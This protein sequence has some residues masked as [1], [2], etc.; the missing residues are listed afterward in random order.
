MLA[1][2]SVREYATTLRELHLKRQLI[3]IGEYCVLEASH[4]TQQDA[5]SQIESIEQ[6]LFSL[7]ETNETENKIQP[8]SKSLSHALSG[9]E[10]AVKNKGRLTGITT[11]FSDIDKLLGGAH[12]SDLV[13]LAGRPSMGKTALALN[14]AYNTAKLYE[15]EK[16]EHG[17]MIRVNGGKVAV[18]SLEMSSTQ[19]AS[20]LL[21]SATRL[22]GD[23][24]R[25]G[26]LNQEQFTQIA[27]MA[28]EIDDIPLFIDDTPAL[29]VSAIRQRSRR[30]KRTHGLDMIVIDY[31]QLLQLPHG[32]RADNRVQEIS[33]ITRNLKALAKELDI[34]VIALSQ[35][36]RAVESRDPPIPQLSDLRDSGAIEQD[37]DVVMFLYRAEYYLQRRPPEIRE[38][39]TD[40]KFMERQQKYQERLAEV[41]NIAQLFIAKQRHGPVGTVDLYFNADATL[42]DDFSKLNSEF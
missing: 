5:D 19:L 29:T 7:A 15:E 25:R 32:S 4:N 42:F 28:M 26:A 21:S 10:H 33:M 37:A 17:K 1:I 14:I 6:K 13:I 27:R 30:L 23:S 20:R 12:K 16:D 11:G 24:L 39:E 36:S 2:I 41:R 22:P 40:E 8:L 9:I 18:F 38:H 35:L 31:L 34:P 3:D